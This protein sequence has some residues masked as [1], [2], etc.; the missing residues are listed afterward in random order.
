VRHATSVALI[1]L[2]ALIIAASVVQLVLAG[3]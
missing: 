3:R 2:L 1:A